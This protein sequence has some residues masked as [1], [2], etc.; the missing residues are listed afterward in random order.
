MTNTGTGITIRAKDLGILLTFLT[1]IIGSVVDS[2]L[3]RATVAENKAKLDKYPPSVIFTNQK[4]MA[5]D[6]K[7]MKDDMKTLVNAF[8]NFVTE[9]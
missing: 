9:Q 2:A 8:N 3:T 5:D 1:I 6:L 4:N 7:E